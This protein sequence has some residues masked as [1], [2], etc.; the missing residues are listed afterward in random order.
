MCRREQG[1][2]HHVPIVTDFN[3]PSLKWI[4]R[5][6]F[7]LRPLKVNENAQMNCFDLFQPLTPPPF[8]ITSTRKPSTPSEQTTLSTTKA[9]FTTHKP[10]GKIC[11][12]LFQAR[13][14]RNTC[15]VSKGSLIFITQRNGS[16]CQLF[17]SEDYV[18]NS[19]STT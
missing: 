10:E 5:C 13:Y 9:P 12:V 11:N 16:S 18:L 6:S 1:N 15:F 19:F 2:Y 7:S 17:R 8:V 4:Q 14:H 3:Q